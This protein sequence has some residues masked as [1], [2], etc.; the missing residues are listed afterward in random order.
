MAT[1]ALVMDERILVTCHLIGEPSAASALRADR[2]VALGNGTT[3]HLL[4]DLR[5]LL[6]LPDD[7]IGEVSESPLLVEL[8]SVIDLGYDAHLGD[9]IKEGMDEMMAIRFVAGITGA[10]YL[11]QWLPYLIVIAFRKERI[12]LAQRVIVID[13][14][15]Q[16][17]I[18]A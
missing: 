15:D 10:G 8:V 7:E 14:V 2:V 6:P 4:E 1:A 11:A 9:R 5:H 17:D 12:A 16:F 13:Q 3:G 18:A